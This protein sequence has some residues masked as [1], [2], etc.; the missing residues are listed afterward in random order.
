MTTMALKNLHI[1]LPQSLYHLLRSEADRSKKPA[2]TLAR[3]A[4]ESWLRQRQKVAIHKAVASYASQ[5]AGTEFDLD[6]DLE[7]ASIQHLLGVVPK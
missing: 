7:S 2:T 3:Q 1:P 4:I 6:Q 5:S